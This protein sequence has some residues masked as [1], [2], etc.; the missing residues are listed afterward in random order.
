[1]KER[2]KR[3][4]GVRFLEK[5]EKGRGMGKTAIFY[6]PSLSIQ[7]R[8]EGGLWPAGGGAAPAGGPVHGDGREVG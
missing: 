7:N 6:L 4:D 1:L 3:I 8:V 5:G 2:R